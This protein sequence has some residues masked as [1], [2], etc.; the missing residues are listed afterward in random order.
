MAEA[1]GN[2]DPE[3]DFYIG[4][5]FEN[6]LIFDGDSI[7]SAVVT[8]SGGSGPSDVILD[9][10]KQRIAS[11]YVYVWLQNG[12]SGTTYT[13]KCLATSILYSEVFKRTGE[14]EVLTI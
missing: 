4:F 11:P 7:A 1:L 9:G 13:L 6:D 8:E 14:I 3:E 2:K 10:T 12:V 5:N